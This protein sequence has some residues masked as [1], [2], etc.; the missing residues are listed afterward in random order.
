[1]IT[2]VLKFLFVRLPL[3]IFYA[4]GVLIMLAVSIPFVFVGFWIGIGRWA[5]EIGDRLADK[6]ITKTFYF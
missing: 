3:A 6:A 1:M 2:T 5:G 4:L